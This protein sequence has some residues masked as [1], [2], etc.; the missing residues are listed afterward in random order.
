MS[1]QHSQQAPS[2]GIE[3]LCMRQAVQS[4]S[5]VAPTLDTGSGERLELQRCPIPLKPPLLLPSTAVL[6]AASL[7]EATISAFTIISNSCA[8][9]VSPAVIGVAVAGIPQQSAH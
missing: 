2:G 5:F 8:I 4:T 7:S 6:A 1:A 3:T 9:V